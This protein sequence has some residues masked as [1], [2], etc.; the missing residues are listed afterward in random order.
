MILSLAILRQHG[1][2]KA[3]IKRT[4]AVIIGAYTDVAAMFYAHP[5]ERRF[6]NGVLGK[7]LAEVV[8]ASDASNVSDAPNASN[9]SDA[10]DLSDLPPDQ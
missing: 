3:S 6:V 8:H 9:A 5:N 7:F 4:L 10:S 2:T 1:T